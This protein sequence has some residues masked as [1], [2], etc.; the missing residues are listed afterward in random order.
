MR[1]PL[2]GGDGAEIIVGYVA[3][4]LRLDAASALERHLRVCA[5]CREAVSAQEAVWRALDAWQPVSVSS[6]FDRRL[7]HRIAAEEHSRW[8]ANLRSPR[9]LWRPAI[10]LAAACALIAGVFFARQPASHTLA[11]SYVQPKLNIEQVTHA[12]DDMDL[13]GQ[14]AVS[15]AAEQPEPSKKI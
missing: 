1:C 9:W 2:K 8:W 7:F 4:G 10:P 12:L 14:L 5:L 11:Q 13:L 3:G 6:D 15:P